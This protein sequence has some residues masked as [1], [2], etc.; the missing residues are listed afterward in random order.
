MTEWGVFGV[1]AALVSFVVAITAPMMKLNS[2]ITRLSTIIE[3]F[4]RR[5]DKLEQQ[6]ETT[7][8]SNREARRRLH[9]R[10]DKNDE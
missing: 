7:Q 1:V 6:D 2:N 4:S 5:I 10:I 9:E 3:Q 8:V